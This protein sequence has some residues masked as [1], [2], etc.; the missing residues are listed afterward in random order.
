MRGRNLHIFSV[1]GNRSTGDVDTFRLQASRDL[2]VCERRAVPSQGG[3]EPSVVG[4]GVH[5]RRDDEIG[6]A[7][8]AGGVAD[9]VGD[10]RA[11]LD[12]DGRE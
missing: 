11:V 2:L 5:G 7:E 10:D 1:F 9:L 3:G 8:T 4:A 12:V 6:K